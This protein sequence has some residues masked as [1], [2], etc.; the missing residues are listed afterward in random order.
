[1]NTAYRDHEIYNIGGGLYSQSE[2]AGSLNLPPGTVVS[3][4]VKKKIKT[5]YRVYMYI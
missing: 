2:C 1:M 5:L 4:E 3:V